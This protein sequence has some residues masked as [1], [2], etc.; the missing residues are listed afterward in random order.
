MPRQSERYALDLSLDLYASREWRHAA[1]QDISRTG[2]FIAT[3]PILVG[4]PVLVSLE[5]NGTRVTNPARVM[6][7]ITSDEARALCRVPGIGLQFHEPVDVAFAVAIENLMR[8]ARTKQPQQ[9]HMVVA[10][11]ELRVLE[12]LSTALDAAGFSVATASNGLEVFGACLRQKPDVVLVDR[13]TPMVDGFQLIE[14]LATDDRM[15]SVPVVVTT[16]DPSDIER[17]FQRGAADVI[18]KPFA[19]VEAIARVRRVAETPKRAERVL[20]TGS[21]SELGIASVLTMME[22]EKKTGRL[23]ASNGHAAWIDIVDGRIVDAGW[24][25]G[26][27]HPRAVV[28]SVLDWTQGSFKLVAVPTRHSDSDLA[29]PVTHLILEQ[30][31]LRDEAARAIS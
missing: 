24:S 6:H 12:R 29:M 15:S 22:I 3:S 26:T 17:A 27:S 1:M 8:R 14:R 16:N 2:M 23:V 19:L 9:F 20:L 11:S 13:A 31:R 10:D 4:T 5:H 18:L 21:I 7:T 30:A 28:M 25:L